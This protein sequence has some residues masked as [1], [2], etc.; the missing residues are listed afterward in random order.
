[1]AAA[2]VSFVFQIL[3]NRT[4]TRISCQKLGSE[5]CTSDAQFYSAS[6]Q[7][8]MLTRCISYDRFRLSVCLPVCHTLSKRLKLGSWGLHWRIA[9]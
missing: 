1:M 7:L 6:A 5:I 3:R 9:P 4:G 8:A 2:E